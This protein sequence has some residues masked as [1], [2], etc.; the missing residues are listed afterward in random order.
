MHTDGRSSEPQVVQCTRVLS[1]R[2]HYLRKVIHHI[3]FLSLNGYSKSQ[4]VC[5]RVCVCV[6]VWC[7][8]GRSIFLTDYSE[9]I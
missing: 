8:L 4:I 6:C 7:V 2:K 3:V 5:V 9:H 1:Q